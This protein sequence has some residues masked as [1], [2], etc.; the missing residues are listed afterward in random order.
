MT[1]GIQSCS[2]DLKC[3]ARFIEQVLITVIVCQ[4]IKQARIKLDFALGLS[5]WIAWFSSE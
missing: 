1:S 4:K 5:G 2:C 3:F